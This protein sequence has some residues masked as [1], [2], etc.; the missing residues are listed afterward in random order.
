MGEFYGMQI[1]FQQRFFFNIRN[2]VLKYSKGSYI[3]KETNFALRDPV[4]KTRTSK[5]IG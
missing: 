5:N 4:N 2:L 1:T 3:E